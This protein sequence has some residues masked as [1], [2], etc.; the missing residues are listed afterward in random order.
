MALLS[1]LR[2]DKIGGRDE[3]SPRLLLELKDNIAYPLYVLFRKS[4]DTGVVP[5]YQST[6]N[7]QTSHHSH[8]QAGSSKQSRELQTSE[9]DESSM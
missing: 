9:F 4:L 2:I 3:L 8:L 1:K 5:L 6:G 7:L